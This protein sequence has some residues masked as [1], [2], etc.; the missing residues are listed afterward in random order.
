MKK[1][2]LASVLAIAASTLGAVPAAFSQAASGSSDQIT[3][4]DP[5]EF[6]AYQNAIGTAAPAAKAAALED[7]LTKY[8]STVVKNQV[9]TT[10]LL[11]Y[12]QANDSANLLKTA[13]RV[14]DVDPNRA[15][16]MTRRRSRSPH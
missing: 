13:K 1:V 16:S 4:K 2:V 11:T 15:C 3:I 5:A 6:N 7:F 8:P 9:L 14:L 12:Q 10:L